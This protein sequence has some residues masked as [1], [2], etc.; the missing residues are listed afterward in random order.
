M[1]GPPGPPSAE[2]KE[3][4]GECGE[5]CW[6]LGNL[7][8]VRAFCLGGSPPWTSVTLGNPFLLVGLQFPY[9]QNKGVR[10]Y[11]FQG[12]SQLLIL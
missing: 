2:G 11:G 4:S 6:S 10:F 8:V 12:S 3:N 1:S 7:G 9:L 5:V